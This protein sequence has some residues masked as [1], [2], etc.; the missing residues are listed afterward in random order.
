MKVKGRLRACSEFWRKELNAPG[1]ILSI[2]E[3]GYVLPL[4]SVPERYIG[5]NQK[6]VYEHYA[7]A[8]G[9]ITK[10]LSTGAIREC[11]SAP[12]VC[13]PLLVVVNSSGKER[14]VINLRHLI[15]TFG[16][17]NSSM[18]ICV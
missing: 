13:S 2:V 7:F 5:P 8:Q 3:N 10:L 6:S 4:L 14:L 12:H 17:I 18:K 1:P 16:K 9:A 15:S 11:Q